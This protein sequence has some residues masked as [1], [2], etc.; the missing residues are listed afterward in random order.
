MSEN[1]HNIPVPN[2]K[3]QNSA[4]DEF[5]SYVE[6][7][8]ILRHNCPWDKV[9]TTDSIAPLTIEETYEMLDA[10]HRHDD[11][12]LCKELGDILL[13]VVMQSVIAEER[14]AFGIVDVIK[15]NFGKMVHRHPH[16]FGEVVAKN[17]SDVLN[18]WE[19]LK[20]EEGQKSTLGGVP[21]NLPALL[22]AERIQHKAAHVGFEWDNVEDV[23]AKVYEELNEF[24]EE[25]EKGN[26]EK[27]SEEFGDFLFAVVNLSRYKGINCEDA[28]E[29][30]NDKF[31]RRFQYIE[32]KAAEMGKSMKDMT[33]A[34][35]D[36]IWNEAKKLEN[37]NSEEK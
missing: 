37:S 14:G 23:W 3:N 33:L 19:Q 30:T 28:L 6:L 17:A 36:S 15:K 20:K 34:E 35:M 13:H 10:V 29:R 32:K 1:N 27:M 12:D 9:Q 11:D 18:N 22:R 8:K 24:H 5:E 2:P 7:I 26:N 4:A 25:L 16:V 21:K 31:T